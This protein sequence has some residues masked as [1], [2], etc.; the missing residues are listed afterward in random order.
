MEN[1]GNIVL[2]ILLALSIIG[3]GVIIWYYMKTYDP[4]GHKVI[5]D[6]KTKTG[7]NKK[8]ND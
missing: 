1:A 5:E 4:K 7:L 3:A 6:L 2:Y 8:K